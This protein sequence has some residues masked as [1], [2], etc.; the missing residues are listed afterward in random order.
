MSKHFFSSAPVAVFAVAGVLGLAGCDIVDQ[1]NNPGSLS[2]NRFTASP[3][4]IQPGTATT[5]SWDVDG[6]DTIE[7]DHGVGKVKEKDSSY[8]KPE[9]TTTYTLTARNGTSVATQSLE[10]LV[11]V[12]SPS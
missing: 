9:R 1:L 8:V 4:Q 12:A 10:V 2:V 11:G 5:L 6:A 3:R 7:I